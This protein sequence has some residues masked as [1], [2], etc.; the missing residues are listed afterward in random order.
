MHDRSGAPESAG[1]PAGDQSSADKSDT[2][3]SAPRSSPVG[4]TWVRWGVLLGVIV[5]IA[6]GYQQ[7]GDA[8]S[9]RQLASQEAR[10]RQ[11]G[12]ENPI[13]IY[14]IAFAVYV[15]VTGM[16]LPGAAPLSLLYAWYFGLVRGVVLVSFAST[17]GA[18]T[19]FLLSRFLFRDAIE[20]RFGRRLAKFN[21]ALRRDGPYFL[22]TLRLIPAVPFFAINAV[23]GLTPI[24]TSTFWWVSQLGM[25]PG[26]IVYVYAGS[27]VPSLQRLADDGLEAVFRPAQLSQILIALVLLGVFPLVVRRLLPKRREDI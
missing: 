27:R 13:L 25:L 20:Q 8:L 11:F 15:L 16:S 6:I 2:D 12:D 5:A 24:K 9:L 22:F 26:T 4:I 1:V 14:G 7:F 23:M 17:T 19:A 21:D 3:S 10:L 18:T